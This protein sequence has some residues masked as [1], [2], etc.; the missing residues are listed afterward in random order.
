MFTSRSRH[1]TLSLLF[2]S[3]IW[4]CVSVVAESQQQESY[5]SKNRNS[6]SKSPSPP[7]GWGF[8]TALTIPRGG[9]D[10]NN[11]NNNNNNSDGSADGSYGDL[12]QAFLQN[13]EAM[14]NPLHNYGK[15]A[16]HMQYLIDQTKAMDEKTNATMKNLERDLLMVWIQLKCLPEG[17]ST[18]FHEL[19]AE[20]TDL[21]ELVVSMQSVLR[22]Y[23]ATVEECLDLLKN[24]MSRIKQTQSSL[25]SFLKN[26]NNKS[27]TKNHQHPTTRLR[28]R[29]KK[30]EHEMRADLQELTARTSD[31]VASLEQQAKERI[32]RDFLEKGRMVQE[33]AL[34]VDAIFQR[35]RG[36]NLRE[37]AAAAED[38]FHY[39][40][41]PEEVEVEM[42]TFR[43][44]W[45]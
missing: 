21:K 20:M 25:R 39:G 8:H 28:H 33:K 22:N 45:Y 10:H 32:W 5:L 29:A 6:F 11:N 27:N 41:E 35:M 40:N 26:N 2:I 23:I 42:T 1:E 37:T 36:D 14:E 24:L 15:V 18:H 16:D 7:E 4:C 44:N 12:E 30:L 34:R 43:Y 17:L 19:Y 31:R 38:E 9:G 3:V 13:V